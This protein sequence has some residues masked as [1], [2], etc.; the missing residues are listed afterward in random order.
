M[1]DQVNP[2]H[3]VLDSIDHCLGNAR[4]TLVLL[5]LEQVHLLR[6]VLLPEP[7]LLR[8]HLEKDLSLLLEMLFLVLFVVGSGLFRV[9]AGGLHVNELLQ[10]HHWPLQ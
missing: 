5:L 2:R 1:V 6:V 7:P 10:R 8:V 4:G 3:D 9:H